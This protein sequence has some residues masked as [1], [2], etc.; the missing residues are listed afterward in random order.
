MGAISRIGLH[1]RPAAH[2][3]TDIN[4][5]DIS[6]SRRSRAGRF[7]AGQNVVVKGVEW[8]NAIPGHNIDYTIVTR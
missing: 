5:T 8:M 2:H 1:N 6:S 7:P 4:E 3:G